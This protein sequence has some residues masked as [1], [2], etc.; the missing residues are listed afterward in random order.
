MAES[1]LYAPLKRAFEAQGYCVFG[2][3][4]GCDLAA[5]RGDELVIVEMKCAF[6]LDLVFQGLDRQRATADVYLAIE[7]PKRYDRKRRRGM[8]RL[9]RRLGL[10]LIVVRM[11]RSKRNGRA[12]DAIT[13]VLLDP[14]PYKPR[15][16]SKRRKLILNEIQNRSADYNT[17]GCT[18][19][20]IV[21]AYRE[22]ALRIAHRLKLNGPCRV[23]QL[24]Q[25]TASKRTAGILL[26]N[27]YGWFERVNRGVY[28][29]TINGDQ[30]LQ[31]YGHVLRGFATAGGELLLSCSPLAKGTVL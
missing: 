15:V 28:Q 27:Y 3:V 20:K 5:R 22:E 6:N 23:R 24:A 2:E 13:E 18:R 19:R 9:C 1:D 12:A 8:L 26:N 21:T 11:S 29:L 10:G 17:G 14:A 25:E 16:D 31:T 7:A 30:A 4:N